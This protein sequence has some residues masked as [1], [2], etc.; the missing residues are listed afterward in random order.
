M[1]FVLLMART[2]SRTVQELGETMDS[3]EFCMWVAEFEANPWDEARADLRSG[4]V[5]ATIAN[6]AGKSRKENAVAAEPID[7]MP[8]SQPDP[9]SIEPDAD[10]LTNFLSEHYVG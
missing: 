8:Y 3:A 4:I 7:F 1:S 10:Y 5:A 6:Y 9:V 2:M